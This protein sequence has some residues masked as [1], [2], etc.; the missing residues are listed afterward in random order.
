MKKTTWSIEILPQNVSDVGFIPDLIKEIYITMI[1]GTSFTDT[2]LAAQKIQELGKKAVPHLTARSFHGI[3][4]LRTYLSGLQAS[5]IERILLIGG[6]VP[7]PAGVFSSVMD[8]LKTELFAEYG[9][10]SFDFAGH[11]EGNPDDPD[12][13]YHLL[14]KLKWTEKR[15]I[16]TRIVTQWCLDTE[17][18]NNW[19][20][21][22]RNNGVQ[23]PINLGIPGRSTLRTLMRF[24]KVC[25]V[26]A[27]T[28]VLRKQGLNISKLMF[29]NKPDKIVSELRG[30]DQLHLYPFGGVAKSSD[31]LNE[32][33]KKF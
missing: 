33:Q 7:K 14:E 30:Y 3:E 8:M 11:P 31:W 29:V 25:G 19:I 20:K 28:E 4:E 26:K 32:W 6:G 15:K 13:D 5:G 2:I 23:N 24:A 10:N 16:P 12:S 27:S 21:S 9:I 22:L 1:P 18:T 17:K